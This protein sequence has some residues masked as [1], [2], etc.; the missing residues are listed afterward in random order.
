MKFSHIFLASAL[1]ISTLQAAVEFPG[2]HPGKAEAQVS[3]GIGTIGN[4]LFT[5]TFRKS[6]SGVVFGGM[7]TASGN[8]MDTPQFRRRGETP[9]Q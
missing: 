6:G 4:K 9:A 1:P 3:N 7:K 8:S 2:K 5:A